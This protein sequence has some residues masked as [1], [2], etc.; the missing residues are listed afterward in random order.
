M[1][2]TVGSQAERPTSPSSS[3]S[4][5]LLTAILRRAILDFV[6]YRV[7]AEEERADAETHTTQFLLFT[8]AAGWL[9]FDGEEPVDEEGRYSFQFICR[10][11][12]LHPKMLRNAVLRMTR[13][14]VPRFNT[15]V[16]DV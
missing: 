14:D 7:I 1:F 16:G 15:S 9:F 5:H 12:D 10:V 3:A 13:E 2:P 4:R 8:D 6:L 11:L